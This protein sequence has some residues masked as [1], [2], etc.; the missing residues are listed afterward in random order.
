MVEA[1]VIGTHLTKFFCVD[2]LVWSKEKGMKL[3]I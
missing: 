3:K 1:K 2:K